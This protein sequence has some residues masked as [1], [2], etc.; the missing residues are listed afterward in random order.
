MLTPTTSHTS[1]IGQRSRLNLNYGDE[2]LPIKLALQSVR[3]WRD[4]PTI[5]TI[6]G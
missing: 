5:A 2:K 4:T 6:A 1:F 3:T